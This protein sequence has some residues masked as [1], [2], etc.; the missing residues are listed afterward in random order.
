MAV[1]P[2][3]TVEKD[4]VPEVYPVCAV[5]RVMAKRKAAE[6]DAEDIQEGVGLD[7]LFMENEESSDEGHRD[8]KKAENWVEPRIGFVV[9]REELVEEQKKRMKQKGRMTLIMNFWVSYLMENDILMRN[10]RLLDTPASEH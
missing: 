4:L 1:N 9:R 10:W 2:S 5:T 7:A 6:G 8:S 3:L